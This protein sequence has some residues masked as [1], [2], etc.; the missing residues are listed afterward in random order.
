MNFRIC[1]CQ[2]VDFTSKELNDMGRNSSD[3]FIEED[4][5]EGFQETNEDINNILMALTRAEFY[6]DELGEWVRTIAVY[7]AEVSQFELRLGEVIQRNS[8]PNIAARVEHEQDELNQ[9]SGIFQWLIRQIERQ[10]SALKTDSRLLD[11]TLINAELEK[12]QDDLRRLMQEAEK[13][14]IAKKHSCIN[15]LSGIMKK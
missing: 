12:Q 3:E 13:E 15:F 7:I 9:V 6:T 11:D 4:Y 1:F 10:E 2:E 8:I 5:E 14:Y